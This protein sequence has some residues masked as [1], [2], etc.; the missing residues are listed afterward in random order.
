MPTG[1]ASSRAAVSVLAT[2]L[3]RLEDQALDLLSALSP[4]S[5]IGRHRNEQAGAMVGLEPPGRRFSAAAGIR[6]C[7]Q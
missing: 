5:R 1:H 2:R 3:H 6:E 7:C 4:A